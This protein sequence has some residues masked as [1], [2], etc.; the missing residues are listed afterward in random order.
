[1]ERMHIGPNRNHRD[2]DAH[3][4][5]GIQV[6]SI[7]HRQLAPINSPPVYEDLSDD[8]DFA[9]GV[10]GQNIGVDRPGEG[11]R[12]A[13]HGGIGFRGYKRGGAGR[14]R[15]VYDNVGY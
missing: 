7:P 5:D 8:E 3:D 2:D 13:V 1:M 12:G 11:R 10:F 9:E 14:M 6:R 4:D 15:N